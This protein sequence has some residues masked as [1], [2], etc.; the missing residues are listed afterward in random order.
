MSKKINVRF[1]ICFIFVM[2]LMGCINKVPNK[3]DLKQL[4]RIDI[5]EVKADGSYGESLM[6]TEEKTLEIIRKIF[7]QIKWEP[8]VE[9]KMAREKDIKAT[10]F[11]KYDENMPERL[12][13]YQIWFNQNND[14]ATIIS[15][16]EKEGYGNLDKENAQALENI[17]LNK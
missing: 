3:F 17:L 1:V 5:E 13:E 11:Y 9:S 14:T 12:F 7:K 4:T 16:N 2:F 15:N 10:L 8:N 6:I